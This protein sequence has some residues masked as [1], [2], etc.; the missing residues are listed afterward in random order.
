MSSNTWV[1]LPY[2][3]M[4]MM[5][6]I[7]IFHLVLY[8]PKDRQRIIDTRLQFWCLDG[9][10]NQVYVY[11]G[12]MFILAL[13]GEDLLQDPT[14]I[15]LELKSIAEHLLVLLG[16]SWLA[17]LVYSKLKSLKNLRNF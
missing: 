8:E 11:L 15:K 16:F 14:I 10:I 7:L 6:I 5:Y 9:K 17:V 1:M 4:C 3:S 12:V 2:L 13:I